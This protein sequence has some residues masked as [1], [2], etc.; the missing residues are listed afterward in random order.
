M[1][2]GALALL[3]G[4][5]GFFGPDDEAMIIAGAILIAGGTISHSITKLAENGENSG[6]S[7]ANDSRA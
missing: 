7:K 5:A 3:C 4:L 6:D 2:L 1:I